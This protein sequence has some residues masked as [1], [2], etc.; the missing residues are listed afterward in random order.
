MNIVM[1]DI[2]IEYVFTTS[3]QHGL[4]LH[5][6][7]KISSTYMHWNSNFSVFIPQPF[8]PKGYWHHLRLSVSLSVCLPPS[9]C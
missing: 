3:V 9:P 4:N 5:S 2:F 7:I 8:W 6:G 1:L